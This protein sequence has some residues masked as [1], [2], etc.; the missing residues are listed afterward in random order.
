MVSSFEAISGQKP[1]LY[2]LPLFGCK[3]HVHISD[4]LQGKFDPKI[5]DCIFLGYA[6]GV[7]AKIFEHVA[8][9]QRFV[10]RDAIVKSMTW[11]Q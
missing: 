3:L 2:N 7:K 5:K 9:C 6:E 1:N 10:L 11:F 8:T 4:T